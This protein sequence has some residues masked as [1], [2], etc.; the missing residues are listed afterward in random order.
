MNLVQVQKENGL[1]EYDEYRL[2][3]LSMGR[4]AQDDYYL[5]PMEEGELPEE[6]QKPLFYANR[7]YYSFGRLSFACVLS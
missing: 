7:R 2:L 6:I 1:K 5:V 3:M 4:C